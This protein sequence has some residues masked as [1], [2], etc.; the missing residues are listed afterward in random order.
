MSVLDTPDKIRDTRTDICV[1][2]SNEVY[3]EGHGITNNIQFN[4]I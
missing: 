1:T 4:S 2:S 3:R